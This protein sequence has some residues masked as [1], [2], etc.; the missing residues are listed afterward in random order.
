MP[1]DA[2]RVV[3]T[4][5]L[6]GL[7]VYLLVLAIGVRRVSQ[8]RWV[9]ALPVVVWA[10]PVLLSIDNITYGL[11]DSRW[12]DSVL[13]QAGEQALSSALLALIGLALGAAVVRAI[14][15]MQRSGVFK[16]GFAGAALILAAPLLV[17]VG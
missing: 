5:A 1:D 14:P 12:T 4:A 6:V 3:E 11:I 13:G 17:A 10:L 16:A 8:T 15:Q 7:G 9:S 2:A